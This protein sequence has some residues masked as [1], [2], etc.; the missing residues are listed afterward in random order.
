MRFAAQEKAAA[1][2]LTGKP[3]ADVTTAIPGRTLA[4]KSERGRQ[5][6]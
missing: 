5:S 6:S 3:S 2:T 1:Q 4:Q